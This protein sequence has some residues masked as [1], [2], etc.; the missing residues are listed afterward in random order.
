MKTLIKMAAAFAT[1]YFILVYLEFIPPVSFGV[2]LRFW[3]TL[4]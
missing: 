4:I 2:L 1:A 3:A